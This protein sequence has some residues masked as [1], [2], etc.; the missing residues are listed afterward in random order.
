MKTYQLIVIVLLILAAIM[1]FIPSFVA[2]LA[3]G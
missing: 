1:Y 2:E 3:V